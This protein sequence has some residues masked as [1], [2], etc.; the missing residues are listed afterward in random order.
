LEI[1]IVL[2][3]RKIPQ[4]TRRVE[5]YKY[6]ITWNLFLNRED[7]EKI[8]MKPESLKKGLSYMKNVAK[9]S[10]IVV[11]RIVQM[12]EYTR[13]IR[14]D[15]FSSSANPSGIAMA[16]ASSLEEV[17][18]LVDEWVEGITYGG[19]PIEGRLEYEIKPLVEL[20]GRRMRRK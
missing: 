7:L 20:T 16:E 1:Y 2:S 4:D 6:L 13:R 9:G 11:Y 10:K 17:K 14:P 3:A 12:E 19:I 18:K 5:R 8:S 15:S